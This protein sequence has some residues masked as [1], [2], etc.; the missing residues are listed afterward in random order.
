MRVSRLV[1]LRGHIIDSL[2]LPRVLDEIMDSGGDFEIKRID[3]GRQR[4]DPSYA[5]IEVFA[6][7]PKQLDKILARLQAFGATPVDN[8][9]A[10]TE[11]APRDGVFPPNFYATTNLRTEVKINGA[12]IPVEWSEMDC[13]IL[14]E[15]NHARTIPMLNV[16]AGEQIVV[17]HLGVRVIPL[18]RPRSASPSFAF[19]SGGVSSERPNAVILH[20]IAQ[21]MQAVKARGGR[22]LV[23]GGPAIVHTGAGWMLEKLI[24]S[25]Y[26]QLLFAGNALATHDI[27]NAL[28]G[29][30][31]GVSLE[32]GTPLEHGHEHHLRAI[33]R[34]RAAGSIRAAVEKGVLTQG[35]MYACIRHGVEFVL[36]G[37]VRD[38]GPLP[39]VISDVMVAQQ[40]MRDQIHRGVDLVLMISTMLHSIATGNL[41][42]ADVTTV[43]VDIN[44][45][46][47]T[48]LVDRGS[49][50]ARGLVMDDASFLR[51][52]LDELKVEG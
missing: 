14:V 2:I 38:D 5:G 25:G 44:P 11:P 52:L 3:V 41:L 18:E 19:M 33:N 10:Q 39:D 7:S 8:P 12:W 17:G 50:Q 34:I 36:A 24:V 20:E 37:S 43:C 32:Q 31:L 28:F 42:P 22:I 4:T 13:G 51:E 49:F 16:K 15:G 6:D 45:A 1:E 21:E 29:T 26:V 48:K 46:V 23:V 35:V 40:V 27:E 30:S 47:V 9:D